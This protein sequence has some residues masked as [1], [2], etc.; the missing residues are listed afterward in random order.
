VSEVCAAVTHDGEHRDKLGDEREP[1]RPLEEGRYRLAGR[2]DVRFLQDKVRD[3]QDRR[4]E[5]RQ[6]QTPLEA[7]GALAHPWPVL[8]RHGEAFFERSPVRPRYG[9]MKGPARSLRRS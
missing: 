4:D 9:V 7:P 5:H 1:S 3:D 2:A 6:L 8:G